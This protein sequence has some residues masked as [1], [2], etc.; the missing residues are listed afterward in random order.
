MTLIQ[1]YFVPEEIAEA[2]K[3]TILRLAQATVTSAIRR[4]NAVTS[5]EQS[6][7]APSCPPSF[8]ACR[9]F[10]TWVSNRDLRHWIL[11]FWFLS[12]VILKVSRGKVQILSQETIRIHWFK[13]QQKNWWWWIHF[14]RS[15]TQAAL[16]GALVT[17]CRPLW[18]GLRISVQPKDNSHLKRLNIVATQIGGAC[19]CKHLSV[20]FFTQPSPAKGPSLKV[21]HVYVL[22]FWILASRFFLLKVVYGHITLN[23]PVLVRSLKLSKV[24]TC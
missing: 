15:L 21:V 1:K 3:W 22:H 14:S 6:S 16:K 5:D 20:I 12:F 7:A 19:S 11:K 8:P 13:N 9:D 10:S 2:Q 4:R 24:E 23:T 18:A 17:L